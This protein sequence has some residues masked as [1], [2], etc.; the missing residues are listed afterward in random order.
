MPTRNCLLD[1]PGSKIITPA[2]TFSTTLAPII[3]L[4]FCPVFCDV[5]LSS[6]VPDAE[7]ILS[8]ISDEVKAI[9]VPNLIGNKPNWD[10]PARW[11]NETGRG[12]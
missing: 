7:S 5:G 1:L 12:I 11:L 2:C 9:M 10:E 3:Q 6:Y 8:L 4:G